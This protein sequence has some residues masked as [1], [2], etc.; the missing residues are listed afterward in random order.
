MTPLDL[1]RPAV[2]SVH[3]V[4]RFG[5]RAVGRVV[6][7]LQRS[8]EEPAETEHRPSASVQE[9]HV[10]GSKAPVEMLPYPD[11]QDPV[12]IVEQTLE[13]EARGVQAPGS[14]GGPATEP[15]ASSRAEEHGETPL[16]REERE[17]IDAEAEE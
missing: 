7:P 9:H 11:L 10:V 8:P 1:V 12:P 4:L 16:Q 5:L 15:R 6:P 2:R 17:E 13:A 14:A 3:S